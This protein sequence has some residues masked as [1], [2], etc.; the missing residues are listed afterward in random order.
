M[1]KLK[2]IVTGASGFIGSS[3][4]KKLSLAGHDVMGLTRSSDKKYL[5]NNIQWITADLALP[6]TYK[7]KVQSFQPNV[8][9]HLAWQDI[10]DFSLI[11]SKSNLNQSIDFLSLILEMKSCKK[12]LVSGSCFEYNNQNGSCKESDINSA[13]NH[14][15]WAKLSLYSWLLMKCDEKNISLGWMRFFYVYGPGQRPESLI[16]TIFLSLK[17]KKLPPLNNPNNA[18]DYVFIDDVVNSLCFGVT[19]KISSGIFNIGSGFSTSVLDILRRAESIVL[20]SN[21]LTK[22]LEKIAMKS[23]TKTNFWAD[24]SKA[25]KE[26]NW[27]PKTSIDRGLNKTWLDLNS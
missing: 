5:N 15:T 11:K 25:K 18:N 22:K 12:I 20:E 27:T 4:V 3:L 6:V 2:I 9:I 26:L 8:V 23:A 19:H 24:I 1:V 17:N 16:P 21:I 10:P 7:D 13:N 14:F